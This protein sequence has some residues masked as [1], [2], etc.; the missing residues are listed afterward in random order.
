MT[1]APGPHQPSPSQQVYY[2]ERKQ[3]ATPVTWALLVINV[4]AWMAGLV[5]PRVPYDL[6]LFP[7]M[8]LTEPWRLLSSSLVHFGIF[9]I[10]LNM[11][12]LWM[13]GRALETLFGPIRYLVLYLG[14]VLGGSALTLMWS[15]MT[16]QG[17]D[18]MFGGA[19]GGIFGMFGALV[20]LQ[21]YKMI[22]AGN[23][24]PILG[25]NLAI[26]FMLPG[27]GWQAHI[28]GLVVGAGI[29]WAIARRLRRETSD[30]TQWI[31][32]GL[33]LALTVGVV[34]ASGMIA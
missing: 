26:S 5:W 29:G 1:A 34:V 4:L 28:G 22:Q 25:L 21:A 11:L 6:A 3:P 32:I 27:I 24:L 17:L 16:G 12:A 14:A 23:L 31:E 2:V 30:Q 18:A 20:V 8:G 9:H 33:I 10:G 15:A 13:L 19:S 7:A